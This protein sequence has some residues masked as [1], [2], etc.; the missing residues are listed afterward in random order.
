MVGLSFYGFFWNFL[1]IGKNNIKTLATDFSPLFLLQCY[2]QVAKIVTKNFRLFCLLQ[3]FLPLYEKKNS[4]DHRRTQ[5][6]RK[7]IVRHK[8]RCRGE[9]LYC[10]KS[11][12]FFI[13]SI[14]DL[15]YHF[16]KKHSVP[17][18][19]ITHKCKLCRAE[20]PGFYALRQHKNSQHGTQIRFAASNFDVE[21]LVEDVDVQGLREELESCK[22][23]LTF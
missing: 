5:V 3:K 18:P 22:Y 17:S 1:V 9:T 21:D 16:V 4:C 8:K 7:N 6:T 10:P 13:K 20:F 19:S 11:P 12:N 14:D 2:S 15:N 23:F